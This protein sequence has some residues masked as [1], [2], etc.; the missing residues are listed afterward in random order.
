M[1]VK[2]KKDLAR[3]R[4]FITSDRVVESPKSSFNLTSFVSI[5]K[6]NNGIS[7]LSAPNFLFTAPTRNELGNTLDKADFKQSDSCGESSGEE[8]IVDGAKS[9][10]C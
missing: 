2:S 6:L 1:S 5:A 3:N 4:A 7:A 10:K 8:A 9:P